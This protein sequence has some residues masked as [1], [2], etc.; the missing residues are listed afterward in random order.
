MERTEMIDP[1]D[2]I[3]PEVRALRPYSLRFEPALVKLN[4]NENPWNMP[5]E[6]RDETFKRLQDRAWSRYPPLFL[7]R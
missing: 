4:Q 7:R 6:I 5:V 1:L 3:K 2:A